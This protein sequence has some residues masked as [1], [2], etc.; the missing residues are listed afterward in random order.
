[1]PELLSEFAFTIQAELAEPEVIGKMAQGVRRYV[2]I[3]GGRVSGPKLTG[4]V[5]AGGG[6]SQLVLSDT[7]LELEARYFLRASDG[8]GISVVNKGLRRA[9]KTVTERLLRG[10]A[11]GANEYY[12]RTSPRF[13]APADS[14]HAWLN[15][16][17]FVASAERQKLAV[18][19]HVHRVL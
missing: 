14:A 13:E 6:D 4:S 17:L 2:R 1:M 15:E 5:L 11:V 10:E 8:T 16:S 7:L 19:V 12:F 3:L 9:P 18:I